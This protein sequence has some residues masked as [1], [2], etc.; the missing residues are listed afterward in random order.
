MTDRVEEVPAGTEPAPP[1]E[2]DGAAPPDPPPFDEAERGLAPSVVRLW[3]VAVLLRTLGWAA[4]VALFGSF[5]PWPQV[6]W[7]VIAAALAAAGGLWAAV[8]PPA[9]FRAWSFRMRERDLVVRFGVLWRTVSVIPYSRIQHVDTRHGPLER[10][11]GLSNLIIY[12]AGV[13][14]A[15]VEIPGLA[16]GEAES[17]REQL[18]SLGGVEDAV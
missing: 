15:D 11:L 18:A 7:L 8:W 17:L 12:T 16:A 2:L 9:R 13:R 1:A 10:W 5:S 6:P 3:R 4:A 14:G